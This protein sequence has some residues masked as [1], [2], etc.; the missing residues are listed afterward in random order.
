MKIFYWSLWV[1]TSIFLLSAC[2]S[3]D[4]KSYT[5]DYSSTENVTA[6]VQ[7]LIIKSAR[8]TIEVKDPLVVS[9]QIK[10]IITSELGYVESATNYN[11]ES[12]SID[13]KVPSEK[14]EKVVEL[15]ASSGKLV[16]KSSSAK[17]V[18]AEMV[19][20]EAK[21]KNLTELRNRFRALLAK[22]DSVE[23][24]LSIE[25]QLSRVQTEIDSIEGRKK[26]LASQISYSAIDIQINK[27]TTYG[28]VAYVLKGI[29]WGIKKLF[30][31]E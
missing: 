3:S 15:V 9:D 19:D 28:P 1:V 24:I 29:Y 8:I 2:S 13:A 7:R 20:I 11:Q 4:S 6:N 10:A 26:S 23:D 16:S 12:V 25:S 18:T 17:D 5:R 31:I 14:L 22:A 30:I 21:L 27:K